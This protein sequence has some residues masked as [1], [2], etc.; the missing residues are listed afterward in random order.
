MRV[1]SIVTPR[2]GISYHRIVNP[3]KYMPWETGDT[4]QMLWMGEGEIAIDC[5]VLL[6][7]KYITTP[8]QTLLDK[9]AQG[10]KIVLDMDDLWELPTSH[11]NYQAWESAGHSK[12]IEEHIRIADI[13]ICTS[14]ILQDKVRAINKNTVVV[15]NAFPYEQE[16][17]IA[18]PVQHN[19][20]TF[21]YMGGSTHL[22]DVKL[23]EGKFRRINSDSFIKNN[24]EFVLAG[25]EK[26]LMKKY[27]TPQDRDA[28]NNNYILEHMSNGVYDRMSAVF[29]YTG[30]HRVLPTTN[31]D[32][33]ID[34]YDQADVALVPLQ[35]NVW[36]SMK[37][38]LKIAEAG[39]KNIPVICSKVQPYYPEL[40][41]CP[42]ILWVETPQD[43]L[44]HIKWCI[45]NPVQ[46]IDMGKQ[47]GDYCR[48]HY[49]LT[50]WNKTRYQVFKSLI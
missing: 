32:D 8:I 39:V 2:S 44:E 38:V 16:S 28:G 36:N 33:Y 35:D 10:M 30:S 27:R 26:S 21:M 24:A 40:K 45:K 9:K 22:P 25:Y 50:T 12:L 41:N 47:L 5:D 34:Y 42:G 1:Q 7:N 14:M 3:M 20:V 18:Q 37:S 29:S 31:L 4:Y 23:L 13:V 43:W 19:K 46:V 48:E 49:E 17:Y 6:Y 11:P 15:P